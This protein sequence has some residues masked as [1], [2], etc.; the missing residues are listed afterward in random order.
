MSARDGTLHVYALTPYAPIPPFFPSFS[1]FP[2]RKRGMQHLFGRLQH[3]YATLH[4]LSRNL[5]TE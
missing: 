2:T 5:G 1:H 4:C 3:T